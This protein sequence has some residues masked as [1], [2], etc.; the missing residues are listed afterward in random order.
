MRLH[1][2][3]NVS[4]PRSRF[5]DATGAL[6]DIQKRLRGRLQQCWKRRAVQLALTLLR[7]ASVI[8]EQKKCLEWLVQ[9]FDCFQT[10]PNNSQLLATCNIQNVGRCWP[11]M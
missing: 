6:R 2:P 5:L 9:K 10:F 7:Y 4:L 8:T 11:T 1:G 3:N